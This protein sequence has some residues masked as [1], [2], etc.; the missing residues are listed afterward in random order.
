MNRSKQF[1]P[2]ADLLAKDKNHQGPVFVSLCTRYG[3]DNN[4]HENALIKV[5]SKYSHSMRYIKIT[6]EQ[7]LKIKNELKQRKN[8]VTLLIYQGEIQSIFTGMVAQY[9]LE[10]ALKNLKQA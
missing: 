9:K 1:S 2:L 4:L 5:L 6:G 8:P 7:A 10:D 3:I